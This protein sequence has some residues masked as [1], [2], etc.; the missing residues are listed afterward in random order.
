MGHLRSGR[1]ATLEI[2]WKHAQTWNPWRGQNTATSL[3]ATPFLTLDLISSQDQG[4]GGG[5]EDELQMFKGICQRCS[6]APDFG[7]LGIKPPVT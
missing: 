3:A 7:P 1:C 6:V 4:S 2:F 5:A